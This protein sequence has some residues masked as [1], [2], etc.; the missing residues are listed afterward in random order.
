ME[1]LD[2]LNQ[3]DIT[4]SINKAL[5]EFKPDLIGVSIRNI[6]DQNM[7]DPR[8]LLD[9]AKEVVVCCKASSEAPVVLGGAG[10]SIFPEEALAY[11]GADMGIQGDGEQAFCLLIDRITQKQ[12]LSGLPGLYLPGRGLQGTRSHINDLDGLPLPDIHLLSTSGYEP[13]DLWIPVQTRRGCPLRCSYCST[14]TI[15]GHR[16]RK[17]SPDSLIPWLAKWVDSGFRRFH[18]V[19]NTFNLPP[20]YAEALC[21]RIIEAGLDINWRC[22]LYPG[23]VHESLIQNMMKAGCREVALGFESG[24]ESI[25]K[26]MNKGFTLKEIRQASKMLADHGIHRTGFLLLGGPGENRK[27]VEESLSFVDSLDLDFLKLTVGV[28][29]Y[30]GTKLEKIAVEEGVISEEENLLFPKFFIVKEIED[31]L[32]D[33]VDSCLK[34]HKNWVT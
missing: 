12:S 19:D 11:L 34:E 30:P 16:I 5:E 23:K 9:K 6:D 20:S 4:V 18:F 10:Y 31:W 21:S 2:L 27:T 28:R 33:A 29:I 15:E 26:G 17:R 25:L 14:G 24:S 22:I 3:E 1:L 7:E 8:F 13:E 32:R